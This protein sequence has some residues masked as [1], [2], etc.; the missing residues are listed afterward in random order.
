MVIIVHV[1]DLPRALSV[2]EDKLSVSWRPLGLGIARQHALEGH[3]YALD[4]VDRAP[5]VAAK[6]IEADVAVAVDVWVQWD[7][8]WRLGDLF[9]HHLW[10]FYKAVSYAALW[11]ME[12]GRAYWVCVAE[13]E[14]E[15][16][17]LVIVDWVVV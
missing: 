14:L 11:Q 13:L 7:W 9:K 3:A 10:G 5:A 15:A 16:E 6:E 1:A 12:V 8:A 17:D 2:V 4:V